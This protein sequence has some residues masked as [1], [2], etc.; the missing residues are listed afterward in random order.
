MDFGAY[1]NVEFTVHYFEKMPEW[2]WKIRT[3][4]W[5]EEKEHD[6]L[7]SNYT[8]VVLPDG[9]RER[10]I[11]RTDAEFAA[12]E[13]WLTFEATNIPTKA[14]AEPIHIDSVNVN[15]K[16]LL[17]P[18]RVREDKE[19]FM[20]ILGKLRTEMVMELWAAVRRANPQW[21][22]NFPQ[23]NSQETSENESEQED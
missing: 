14:D 2:A 4:S 20:D 9:T 17:F 10:R 11:T 8:V 15:T 22:P 7:Y 13:I 18:L 16:G 1:G 21:L 6:K 5:K 19:R 23:K 3:A 12:E